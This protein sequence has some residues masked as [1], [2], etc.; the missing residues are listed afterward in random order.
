MTSRDQAEE[1]SD[2]SSDASAQNGS[3]KGPDAGSEA[4][5]SAV[6]KPQQDEPQQ[7]EPRQEPKE[8]E[9]Q[10]EAPAKEAMSKGGTPIHRWLIPGSM[11]RRRIVALGIYAICVVVFAAVAGPD[12]I[13]QH[14]PFNHYAHLANAWLHGRQDLPGGAP[15]YAQ[16]N[17]FAEFEGKTYISFPP[18][19]AVLMLP[20]VA[21][22]G[23]PE[24]F[25][26]GQFVVWLAGIGP[27]LL[28][29]VLE[30][31]RDKGRSGWNERFNAAL[32]LIFA[33]G[34]GYF[35]TAV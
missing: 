33:F 17:D 14:T 9:P 20:F 35:F 25:R 4:A 18:F 28:F 24:A 16:G 7:D 32:S 15:S 1:A 11:A 22:A 2:P 29:L 23:S 34:T 30:K 21:I 8:D 26:D 5:E 27:A 3:S 19:P 10:G 13:G 12:R 31:L 6:G